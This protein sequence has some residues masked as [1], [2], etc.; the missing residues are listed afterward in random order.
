MRSVSNAGDLSASLVFFSR[1]YRLCIDLLLLAKAVASEL[2]RLSSARCNAAACCTSGFGDM[3]RLQS[4]GMAA[5]WRSRE[6]LLIAQLERTDMAQHCVIGSFS[7][8]STL[9]S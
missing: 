7:L 9:L 8:S 5:C 6:A 2:E 1:E 3:M 4:A